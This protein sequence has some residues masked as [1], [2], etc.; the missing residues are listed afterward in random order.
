MDRVLAGKQNKNI[1][2]DLGV[3]QRTVENHRLRNGQDRGR[4]FAGAGAVGCR[5]RLR[6]NSTCLRDVEVLVRHPST[7][8]LTANESEPFG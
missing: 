7:G 4:V 3:S 1:A 2:V 6:R 5:R 8:S